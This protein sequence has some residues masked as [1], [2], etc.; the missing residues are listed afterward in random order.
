MHPISGQDAR[1][2]VTADWFVAFHLMIEVTFGI[3]F[4]RSLAW[5][6]E[7]WLSGNDTQFLVFDPSSL[8]R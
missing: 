8:P 5:I 6:K 7:V 3:V 1:L 4:R 2:Q